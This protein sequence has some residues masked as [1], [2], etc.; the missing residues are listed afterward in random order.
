[1]QTDNLY[2]YAKHVC[3]PFQPIERLSVFVGKFVLLGL[4]LTTA[5]VGGSNLHG[6]NVENVFSS[7]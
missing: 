5:G 3:C 7:S 4:Q 6:Y 1:M 2:F